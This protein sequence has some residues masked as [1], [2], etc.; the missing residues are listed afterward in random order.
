MPSS[1]R[2][3]SKL[4]KPHNKDAKSGGFAAFVDRAFALLRRGY[5]AV[6]EATVGRPIAIIV[7]FFAILAG[8]AAL[9]F[10]IPGEYTPQEDRGSFQIMIAG[11]EGASF[12]YMQPF[13]EQIEGRLLPMINQLPR[14]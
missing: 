9:F 11:P 8:S 4:L 14:W 5:S 13:I 3:A 7:A 6:Y 1:P 12:E 10:A 2:L